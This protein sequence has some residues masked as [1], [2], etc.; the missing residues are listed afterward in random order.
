MGNGKRK[1]RVKMTPEWLIQ[2]R[3]VR[4]LHRL[5]V[6]Y[7]GDQNASL[8]GLKSQTQAKATGMQAGWPDLTVIQHNKV[9]F[10]E[11]KT[12]KGK[13]SDK[14]QDIHDKLKS[15]GFPVYTVYAVDEDDGWNQVRE[16]L[17]GKTSI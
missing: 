15:L 10:I 17:W 9:T 3:T 5:G 2:A 12:I 8:R 1:A 13:L 11:F 7:Q 14:Q 4:E 6:L 16:I